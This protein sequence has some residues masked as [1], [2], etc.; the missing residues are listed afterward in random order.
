MT[1]VACDAYARAMGQC[2]EREEAQ[3]AAQAAA[4]D[5]CVV[6]QLVGGGVQLEYRGR[7]RGLLLKVRRKRRRPAGSRD[8][9]AWQWMGVPSAEVVTRVV[10]EFEASRTL[11][12]FVHS[13]GRAAPDVGAEADDGMGE[14]DGLWV[15]PGSF[16]DLNQY[17]AENV[18][19]GKVTGGRRS[20]PIV[21]RA[22]RQ[23]PGAR[24]VG[25]P[26]AIDRPREPPAAPTPAPAPT[27]LAAAMTAA[28]A[29]IDDDDDYAAL[30]GED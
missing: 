9:A 4:D 25:R 13:T 12:D 22:R 27:P 14:G 21:A 26:P 29:L 10:G 8:A 6:P 3:R 16:S 7:L 24:P 11:A 1:G 2:K 23:P 30:M 18:P 20:R 28:D 15:A 5:R 19:W 17:P